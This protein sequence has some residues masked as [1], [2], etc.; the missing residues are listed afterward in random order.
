MLGG[1]ASA[2]LILCE[3]LPLTQLLT[4]V[5]KV[6]SNRF[7]K[8]ERGP[9]MTKITISRVIPRIRV[10][11]GWMLELEVRENGGTHRRSQA[12]D[13]RNLKGRCV[14]FVM[15]RVQLSLD[16]EVPRAQGTHGVVAR[17]LIIMVH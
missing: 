4:L 9:K 6:N 17:R 15:M 7:L 1:R 5:L 2:L 16:G 12:D 10:N 13:S 11:L 8:G 14:D 3:L